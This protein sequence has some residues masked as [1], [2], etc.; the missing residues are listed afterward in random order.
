MTQNP[1]SP[2]QSPLGRRKI[3]VK[4]ADKCGN[5]I[6]TIVEVTV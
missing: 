4:V 5:D 1:L 3:V 2:H 6:M